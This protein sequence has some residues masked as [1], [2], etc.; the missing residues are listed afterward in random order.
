MFRGRDP[1]ARLAVI[2]RLVLVREVNALALAVGGAA[3]ALGEGARAGGEL[4]GDGGILLDP[5]CESIFAVLDDAAG[6]S[7]EWSEGG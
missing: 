1:E 6:K 4:G 2:E 3:A 7:V 5:A